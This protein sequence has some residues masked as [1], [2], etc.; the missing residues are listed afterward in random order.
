LPGRGEI[1]WVARALS[2]ASALWAGGC[3][4]GCDG[5]GALRPAGPNVLILTVDTLRADRLGAYGYARDTTPTLD[6]LAREGVRFERTYSPRGSTWPALMTMMT[7]WTPSEHGVRDNATQA[8]DKP[9]ALAEI[10]H[11]KGYRSRAIMAN[12]GEGHW[13]GFDE[14]HI[15]RDEPLDAHAADEAVAFLRE[16]HEAPFLLWVHLCAPHDPYVL[17]ADGRNYVDAAYNGPIDDS[18]GSLVRSMFA[19]PSAPDLGAIVARYDGEVAFADAALGRIVSALEEADLDDSTLVVVSADHGEELAE[20]PP[21]LFHFM[22]PW[23]A[24]LHVPLIARQPGAL[25]QGV[26]VSA[27]VGLV[28]VAPTVLDWL[29]LPIPEVWRGRSLVA[30]VGGAP[31]PDRGIVSEL[32]TQLLVLHEGR[33]ALLDNPVN[34][35]SQLASPLQWQSAGLSS[36]DNRYPL[37][38]LAL[39]DVVADPKQ[40]RDIAAEHPDVVRRMHDQLEAYKVATGW[41]GLT[42]AP[43]SPEVPEK[44]EALGYTIAP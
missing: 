16:P 38:S 44:L 18:Q 11:A 7:S 26:A 13:E 22:S 29:N 20:H 25:P 35:T 28:D 8:D 31:L 3:D 42:P 6:V 2:L 24:V 39:F 10:L 33:W 5:V 32:S 30:A 41:P 34:Y 19:A 27:A 43:P 23:D 14:V 1:R 12:A 9:T 4:S 37:P 40:Q 36:V 15:V 21:Y 17:H